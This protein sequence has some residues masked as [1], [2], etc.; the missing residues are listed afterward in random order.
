MRGSRRYKRCR[1][2]LRK[3]RRHV[4]LVR[5][6]LSHTIQPTDLAAARLPVQ[7]WILAGLI[8]LFSV[9]SSLTRLNVA[10]SDAVYAN[11]SEGVRLLNWW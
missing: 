4:E 10:P 2:R 9:A 1:N 7:A 5:Q 6:Y 3:A 11:L 8:T